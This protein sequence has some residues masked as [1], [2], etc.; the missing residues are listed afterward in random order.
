M[1]EEFTHNSGREFRL[2]VIDPVITLWRINI[3]LRNPVMLFKLI[4]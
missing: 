2:S 4:Q 3:R 1:V